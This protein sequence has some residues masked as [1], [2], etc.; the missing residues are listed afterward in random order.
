MP[1]A[2][3]F[4]MDGLLLDTERLFVACFEHAADSL[5]FVMDHDAYRDC[6]GTT[7]R[8][9]DTILMGAYGPDFPLAEVKRICRKRYDEL[10]DG[11]H[12]NV[13]EGALELLE[14]A[15]TEGIVC[16]LATSTGRATAEKKLALV[17]LDTRFMVTVTGDDVMSGKPHPEPYRKAAGGLGLAT[18]ACWA[19]EDSANG[20]R[21]AVAA[22]CQVF[23]VPDLVA[24]TDDIVA[25]GHTIVDSLEDVA[26]LLRS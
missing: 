26:K 17:D 13:K 23:Q 20:V 14:H 4:D 18:A 3:I 1:G 21:A 6:I 11:G 15:A 5:G 12:L 2:L 7:E 24:P 8:Q 25:L 10:L 19:L 22:G 16:A 9:S